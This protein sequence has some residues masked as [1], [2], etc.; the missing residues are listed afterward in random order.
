ML[1]GG[2]PDRGIMGRM[3]NPNLDETRP[4]P[5][6]PEEPVPFDVDDTQPTHLNQQPAADGSPAQ[7]NSSGE[8]S[9]SYDAT[10]P[11][12][13]VPANKALGQ[14]APPPPPLPPPSKPKKRFH[15][16]ATASWSL[17]GLL[18][19][20]L[21]AGLSAFGGYNEGIRQRK[22][23]EVAQ[24]GAQADA[25]F[26]LGLQDMQD[27]NFDLARQRFEY[28]VELN[29][30]YPGVT[31]KLADVLF[32][33]NATATPTVAPTPTITPTPDTRNVQERFTQAQ[34]DLANSE[35]ST[36]IDSLLALRKADPTYQPVWVDDMLYLSFRNRGKSKIL[37]ADLEG[38]IYD[39]TVAGQF[40]YLDYDSRSLQDWARLYITGASFWELDW[41]QAVFYFA[42]VAPAL[43]NLRDGSGWTAAER[44]RL[45]LIG[46]GDDL[47]EKGE[48]CDAAQQLEL[49]LSM[50]PDDK[51]QKLYDEASNHCSG[52]D[53]GDNN[54]D[55]GDHPKKTEPPAEEVPTEPAATEPPPTEQPPAET[56]YP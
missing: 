23:A 48:W 15:W 6:Q 37:N 55:N 45:A 36:A 31:E 21:I 2:L 44:Y 22:Q 16:P 38:G 5:A 34:Q 33:L 47:A 17:L 28:V 41:A 43:P 13:I 12:E 7:A 25:Q 8:S 49:S 51:A 50:G 3:D 46:Y 52:S 54:G 32:Y 19:L 18:G 27:G 39:M 35:W 24:V 26:Q 9:G 29:P 1:E 20:V 4:T 42:Q 10:V 30:A 11:V 14:V 56:T 53:N 40:G